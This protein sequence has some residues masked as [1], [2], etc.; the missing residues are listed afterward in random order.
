[1]SAQKTQSFSSS[2]NGQSLDVSEIENS[3]DVTVQKDVQVTAVGINIA[4]RSMSSV[5]RLSCE[6]RKPAN[7]G[8][9]AK[10]TLNAGSSRL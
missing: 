4:H 7:E 10:P 2:M 8:I 3:M 6:P 1:M 9:G 5:G